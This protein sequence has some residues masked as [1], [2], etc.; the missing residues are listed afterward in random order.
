MIAGWLVTNLGAS[1]ALAA[2]QEFAPRWAIFAASTTLFFGAAAMATIA[3]IRLERDD[4]PDEEI[5]SMAQQLIQNNTSVSLPVAHA[6]ETAR[7]TR[8]DRAPNYRPPSRTNVPEQDR[9][10]P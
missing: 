6:R 10:R 4:R 1:D 3:R 7:P 2:L 9:D 8:A 5:P